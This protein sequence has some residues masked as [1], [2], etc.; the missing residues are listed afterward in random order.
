MHYGTSLDLDPFVA[1]DATPHLATNDCFTGMNVAIYQSTGSN[2]NLTRGAHT[3]LHHTFN[4]HHTLAIDFS[5][6][7]GPNRDD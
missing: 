5:I 6:D 1:E 3:T 4:L 2:Q 7:S